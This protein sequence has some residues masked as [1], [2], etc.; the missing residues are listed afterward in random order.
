MSDL[1]PPSPVPSHSSQLA[2][3]PRRNRITSSEYFPVPIRPSGSQ[4]SFPLLDTSTFSE[5]SLSGDDQSQVWSSPRARPRKQKSKTLFSDIPPLNRI[6][7][8]LHAL[9]IILHAFLLGML[10]NGIDHR[11]TMPPTKANRYSVML[12][13]LQQTFFTVYQGALVVITQQLALRSNLLRRQTLT[14]LH[15]K[16]VAWGGLGASILSLWRQGSVPTAIYGALCVVLYL[17]SISILHVSSSSLIDVE[18]YDTNVPSV[19]RTSLGLPNMTAVRDGYDTQSWDNAGAVSSAIGQLPTM[20]NYG[21][22]NSTVYDIVMD[23]TGVGTVTVNATTFT[24]KCYSAEQY[25]TVYSNQT[26]ATIEWGNYESSLLLMPL[27]EGA[28]WF[29]GDQLQGEVKG[30]LLTFLSFPPVPDSN[31]A[32]GTTIPVMGTIRGMQTYNHTSTVEN[33]VQVATCSLSYL[34]RDA[35]IDSQTNAL[36]NVSLQMDDPP[37]IWSPNTIPYPTE[38]DPLID[39]FWS[40]FGYSSS[41]TT[42]VSPSTLCGAPIVCQLSLLNLRLA[43]MLGLQINSNSYVINGQIGNITS[44]ETSN[45]TLSELE[46]MLSMIAAQMVWTLGH[47]NNTYSDPASSVTHLSGEAVVFKT[48]LSSR[49]HFNLVP[50]SIGLGMSVVLLVLAHILTGDAARAEGTFTPDNLGIL[51][52]FWLFSRQPGIRE[53]LFEVSEPSEDQLRKAGLVNVQVIDDNETME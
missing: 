45:T 31:G 47:I 49:L 43:S 18:T 16:S 36:L 42:E 25:T 41:T 21:V 37:T 35:I 29:V 40:T 9:L 6:C 13:V 46:E 3:S 34:T 44:S 27:Y 52:L 38:Y 4:Q 32:S 11:I 22:I 17:L 12:T 5:K 15:D 24:V 50:V 1:S 8:V 14:A 33:E 19:V 30:R 39:W 48:V 23:T 2:K 53:S 20:F 7:Y 10:L 26:N 51:Q 28:L